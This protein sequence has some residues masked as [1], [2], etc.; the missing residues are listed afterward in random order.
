MAEDLR[1]GTIRRD[2]ATATVESLRYQSPLQY[3]PVHERLL[4]S[5]PQPPYGVPAF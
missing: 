2:R 5:D 1:R 3:P 4:L